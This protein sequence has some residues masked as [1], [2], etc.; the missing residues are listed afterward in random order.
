MSKARVIYRGAERAAKVI[1]QDANGI[2]VHI[3][4]KGKGGSPKL[5][6]GQHVI[7]WAR[8]VEVDGR[9][10]NPAPGC[11]AVDVMAY[12]R[13]P[14]GGRS[15]GR[16]PTSRAPV[17]RAASVIDGRKAGLLNGE[18]WGAAEQRRAMLDA[19]GALMA[20][21]VKQRAARGAVT[22]AARMAQIPEALIKGRHRP[23][24]AD[25]EPAGTPKRK[26]KAKK[27]TAAKKA[28]R[29]PTAE[30]PTEPATP[31]RRRSRKTDAATLPLFANGAP[32]LPTKLDPGA[33]VVLGFEGGALVDVDAVKADAADSLGTARAM[34][35]GARFG[36]SRRVV[37]TVNYRWRDQPKGTADAI[38]VKPTTMENR[39]RLVV[40]LADGGAVVVLHHV[41]GKLAAA[42]AIAGSAMPARVRYVLTI[43]T[44]YRT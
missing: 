30:P 4:G 33:R 23:A 41:K 10:P 29:T 12:S 35:Q 25:L 26:P 40:G 42:N 39:D 36:G 21:G 7:P 13:K 20:D 3:W 19:E 22:R 16:C 37:A 43:D 6:K 2:T 1:G 34:A 8:V 17:D 27:T 44:R 9:R 31:K 5:G 24:P 38:A 18:P 28:R 15:T 32:S 14:K 11:E